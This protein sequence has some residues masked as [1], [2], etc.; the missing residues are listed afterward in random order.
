MAHIKVIVEA[1]CLFACRFIKSNAIINVFFG[2]PQTEWSVIYCSREE[3]GSSFQLD[4]GF[5]S[6][7]MFVCF[8]CWPTGT[9]MLWCN[10]RTQISEP[11]RGHWNP[12]HPSIKC[13]GFRPQKRVEPSLH[14]DQS[15]TEETLCLWHWDPNKT[16][17]NPSAQSFV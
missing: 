8:P 2:L 16:H 1:T 10:Q 15:L 17:K 13:V 5:V 9:K 12:L 11:L 7:S 14:S 3:G 4:S 6:L